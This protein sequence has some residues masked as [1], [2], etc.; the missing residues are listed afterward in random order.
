[1]AARG[2]QEQIGKGHIVGQAR[3]QRVGFQMIDRHEGFARRQRQSLA[4][5]QPHQHAAD[6]AGSGR[7]GD[8]VEVANGEFRPFQG[9]R[10]EMVDHLDMGA[11]GN[12][13]HHAAIGRMRGDLTHHLVR[14][15]IAAAGGAQP[16]DRRG[17]FIAG[18]LYAKNA[19]SGSANL[20]AKRDA[21]ARPSRIL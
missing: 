7:G 2:E 17:G 4:G 19:H 3:G 13:R 1:M 12:F 18:R 14:K 8:S 11:R 20:M 21:S 16:N 15:D 9:P 5:H 10:D 6:Q